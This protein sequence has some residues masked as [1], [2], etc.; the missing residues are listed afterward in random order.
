MLKQRIEVILNSEIP[1]DE[2]GSKES[3]GADESKLLLDDSSPYHLSNALDVAPSSPFGPPRVVEST[4]QSLGVVCSLRAQDKLSSEGG[5]GGGGGGG[6]DWDK[7]T[8]TE[9]DA[10][11]RDQTEDTES[12]AEVVL[13]NQAAADTFT[14]TLKDNHR[15]GLQT[16]KAALNNNRAQKIGELKTHRQELEANGESVVEIE[17]RIHLLTEGMCSS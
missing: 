10:L 11:M 4:T 7:K 14:Q 16:L 6:G 17:R 9:T 5:G 13:R 8:D 15:N 3:K 2:G 1:Q 12:I